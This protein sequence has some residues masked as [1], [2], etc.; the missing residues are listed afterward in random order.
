VPVTLN[1]CCCPTLIEAVLGATTS[2]FNFGAPLQAANSKMHRSDAT[3][4]A[5]PLSFLIMT[6]PQRRKT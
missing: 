3:P 5:E 1:V 4:N 6:P 2:S